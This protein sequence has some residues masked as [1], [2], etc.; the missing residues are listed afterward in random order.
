MLV[1][2]Y[3]IISKV[4]TFKIFYEASWSFIDRMM[5]CIKEKINSDRLC[6]KLV[7]NVHPDIV[8]FLHHGQVRPDCTP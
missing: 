5:I 1:K 8:K 7:H 3:H 6:I 4:V 2:L